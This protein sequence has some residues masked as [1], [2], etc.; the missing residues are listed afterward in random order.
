MDRTEDENA[1]PRNT[2]AVRRFHW[3][4]FLRGVLIVA[5]PFS[6]DFS[7]REWLDVSR[8]YARSVRRGTEWTVTDQLL[9]QFVM[10][11]Y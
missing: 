8:G 3:P 10:Y 1:T 4:S 5:R 2:R 6:E 11:A 9:L 7:V